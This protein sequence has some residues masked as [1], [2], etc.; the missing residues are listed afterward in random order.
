MKSLS[1]SGQSCSRLRPSSSWG[2]GLNSGSRHCGRS[3]PG[4]YL[5]LNSLR[6]WVGRFWSRN[7]PDGSRRG[8]AQRCFLLALSAPGSGLGT[9]GLGARRVASAAVRL[10]PTASRFSP[11][12][13][14]RGRAPVARSRGRL[15]SVMTAL[16]ASS[17]NPGSSAA[18]KNAPGTCCTRQEPAVP[19]TEGLSFCVL[20]QK[21]EG[22]RGIDWD[23]SEVPL[24]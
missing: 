21:D 11:D 12:I 9:S 8:H 19:G 7:P 18:A 20:Q 1:A 4:V 24:R 23:D 13:G 15:F 2:R 14:R 22:L 16:A 10:Q 3:R 5:L 6:P 17:L